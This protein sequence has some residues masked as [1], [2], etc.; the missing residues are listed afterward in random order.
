MRSI[1]MLPIVAREGNRIEGEPRHTSLGIQVRLVEH[2]VYKGDHQLVI[3]PLVANHT[4]IVGPHRGRFF[5]HCVLQRGRNKKNYSGYAAVREWY[6]CEQ[7]VPRIQQWTE[8][9]S[10][11]LLDATRPQRPGPGTPWWVQTPVHL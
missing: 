1:A 9:G 10:S 11:G 3:V 7:C 4:G 6:Q 2:S 5:L 8:S